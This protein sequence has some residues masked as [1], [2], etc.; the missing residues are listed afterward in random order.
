MRLAVGA[1]ADQRHVA[2]REFEAMAREP[3]VAH[4]LR[5]ERVEEAVRP[6]EMPRAASSRTTRR[7]ARPR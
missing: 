5:I 2:R 4:Q 6:A 1:Q 3:E 7:P